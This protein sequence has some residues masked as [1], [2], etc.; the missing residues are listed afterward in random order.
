M[1]DYRSEETGQEEAPSPFPRAEAVWFL[2]TLLLVVGTAVLGRQLF[3]GAAGLEALLEGRNPEEAFRV[4]SLRGWGILG[5]FL[6]L[7]T[8][9]YEFGRRRWPVS[10]VGAN[11][12]ERDLL[13]GE[14]PESFREALEEGEE[15]LGCALVDE[16]SS[17]TPWILT[18]LALFGVLAT[19][20]VSIVG[21]AATVPTGTSLTEDY[22]LLGWAVVP[23][24]GLSVAMVHP[25]SRALA[26][27]A[28]GVG[29]L[30]WGI[31]HTIQ[32][33]AL[34]FLLQDPLV[35]GAL[36][37]WLLGAVLVLVAAFRRARRLLLLSNR[38]W[39]LLARSQGA[40]RSLWGPLQLRSIRQVPGGVDSVW[41]LEDESGKALRVAPLAAD[42]ER[43]VEVARSAGADLEIRGEGGS[44]GLIG[45][46]R[47]VGV[48]S[49]LIPLYLAVTYLGASEIMRYG[50]HLGLGLVNEIVPSMKSW[51]EAQGMLR[52]SREIS[53]RFSYDMTGPVFECMLLHARG[54]IEGFEAALERLRSRREAAR[55][56]ELMEGSTAR[57]LEHLDEALAKHC[58]L[59]DDAAPPRGWEPRGEALRPFRL[60][61]RGLTNKKRR[62]WGQ[63]WQIWKQD[64]REAAAKAPDSPGVRLVTVWLLY[65][66]PEADSV[67]ELPE[68]ASLQELLP[69]IDPPDSSAEH[70]GSWSDRLGRARRLRAAVLDLL[71]PLEALPE[72]EGISEHFRGTVPRWLWEPGT[73][74]VL[75]AVERGQSLESFGELPGVLLRSRWLPGPLPEPPYAVQDCEGLQEADPLLHWR[76]RPPAS[77]EELLA[78]WPQLSAEKLREQRRLRI[79]VRMAEE[80]QASQSEGAGAGRATDQGDPLPDGSSQR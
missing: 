2:G 12:R 20:L 16:P 1:I 39:R 74:A 30:V 71:A 36:V 48:R 4:L 11:L 80:E 59:G 53:E 46:L 75:T 35:R 24:L 79:A 68:G 6:V 60:A 63:D 49:L 7:S 5:G 78:D 50:L 65:H 15:V 9:L 34:S 27:S 42:P 22:L 57:L 18:A 14:S 45:E 29:P 38:G 40:P 47:Q 25:G 72:W 32:P 67:P 8:A 43:L 21:V 58:P 19:A 3:G 17:R 41:I 69:R 56:P 61:L 62:L 37:L 33:R 31:L 76:L 52:A 28:V 55:W 77:R 44:G 70:A 10:R 23:L 54:D 73:H 64:L 66:G 13:R 26:L 51:E